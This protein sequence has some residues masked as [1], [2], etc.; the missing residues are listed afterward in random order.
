MIDADAIRLADGDTAPPLAQ[1]AE[2]GDITWHQAHQRADQFLAHRQ[3]A[4]HRA[5]Q[6]LQLIAEN[7]AAI[8][9][10]AAQPDTLFARDIFEGLAPEARSLAQRL[11]TLI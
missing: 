8:P 6:A 4:V 2:R 5:R 1:L 11:I 3:E 9:D 7:W 10:L